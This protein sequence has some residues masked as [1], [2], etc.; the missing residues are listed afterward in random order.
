M[1][2]GVDKLKATSRYFGLLFGSLKIVDNWRE[3]L[4]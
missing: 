3:T 4:K 1:F 2:G